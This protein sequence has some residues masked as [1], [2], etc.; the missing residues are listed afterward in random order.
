MAE[1]QGTTALEQ[2]AVGPLS[3]APGPQASGPQSAA[4]G[5]L[6]AGPA[7][8]PQPEASPLGDSSAS[9]APEQVVFQQAAAEGEGAEQEEGQD[10]PSPF[11]RGIFGAGSGFG[12][13]D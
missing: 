10:G 13:L 2:M 7:G 11:G 9:S 5:P 4:P 8:Q 12:H 1:A 6:A 3:A